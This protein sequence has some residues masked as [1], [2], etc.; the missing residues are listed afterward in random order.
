[1]SDWTLAEPLDAA[2]GPVVCL[3]DLP[4]LGSQ[5]LVVLFCFSVCFN[6]NWHYTHTIDRKPDAVASPSVSIS[7]C[8]TDMHR[9][10]NT[11]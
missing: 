11:C 10:K 3:G 9:K 6:K 5:L 1:M 4:T 2:Q 7:M 8:L